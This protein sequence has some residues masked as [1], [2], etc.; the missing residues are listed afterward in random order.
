VQ[1]ATL[2]I[3]AMQGG[4]ADLKRR[5]GYLD[6]VSRIVFHKVATIKSVNP[7]SCTKKIMK[8]KGSNLEESRS[9]WK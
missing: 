8:N 9:G 5:P 3:L 4:S 7:E 2:S 1:V 6:I